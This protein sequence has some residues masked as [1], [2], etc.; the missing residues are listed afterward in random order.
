LREPATALTDYLLAVVSTVCLLRLAR[1]APARRPWGALLFFAGFAAA[2]A[3]GG[4]WHGVTTAGTAGPAGTRGWVTLVGTGVAASGL[5]VVGLERFG[6]GNPPA[7][8]AGSAVFVVA[9][10][11]YVWWDRRFLVAV[12]ASSAATLLCLAGLFQHLRR[13]GRGAGYAMCGL[14]LSLSGAVLQQLGVAIHLVHFDHNAT[15]H[16]WLLA[17]LGFFY[18]GNRRIAAE[19]DR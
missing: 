9:Y 16:L 13:G 18:A 7:L 12:I 5:A 11:A 8:L 3:C 17:A 10:G 15:Y 19:P 4:T 2:A 6:W 14:L 1:V